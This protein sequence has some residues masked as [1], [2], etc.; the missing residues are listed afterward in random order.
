[1]FKKLTL[2]PTLL[3]FLL[4]NP[5]KLLADNNA[6]SQIKLDNFKSIYKPLQDPTL[7]ILE[8]VDEG[9]NYFLKLQYK[10]KTYSKILYAFI[11][12]KSQ[13]LMIGNRYNKDGSISEFPKTVQAIKQIKEGVFFSFGQGKKELYLITDPDCRY[14]KKFE[15]ASQGKLKNYR[16]H[17]IFHPF[18]FHKKSASMVAWIMQGKTEEEKKLRMHQVMVQDS[19]AYNSIKI[20]KEL[21][22][23]IEQG[24]KASQA[25][26]AIGSPLL[27]DKKFRMINTKSLTK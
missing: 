10:K 13:Q 11:N 15:K 20:S 22:T 8:A 23:K 14:C 16:I 17:V 1:M 18:S 3:F 25:L 24:Y 9:E 21:E 4:F 7:T 27:Y 19:K 5:S 6:L 2:I 26:G 12:K